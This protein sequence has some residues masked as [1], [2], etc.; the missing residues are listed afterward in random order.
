[1]QSP[2]FFPA[3]P[4]SPGARC[5][6]EV[7]TKIT[8]RAIVTGFSV[9]ELRAS[10]M[11]LA[12]GLG[13]PREEMAYQI[14]ALLAGS[15]GMGRFVKPVTG[16]HHLVQ[17]FDVGFTASVPA[18]FDSAGGTVY[19]YLVSYLGSGEEIELPDGSDSIAVTP[20]QSTAMQVLPVGMPVPMAG[21][22]P[23]P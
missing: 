17:P 23:I 12:I 11:P 3:A 21:G 18:A 7:Q 9:T 4:L 14:D 1:M 8:Y 5:S 6:V 10:A 20:F 19:L 22:G 16:W 13:A 15:V 2:Q